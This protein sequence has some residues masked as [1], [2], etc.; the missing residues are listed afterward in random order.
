MRQL[1][2]GI[3]VLGIVL[4]PLVGAQA[5]DGAPSPAGEPPS[6]VAEVTEEQLQGETQPTN[7][8]EFLREFLRWL[9]RHESAPPRTK[10]DTALYDVW[11]AALRP[12]ASRMT[13]RV[14]KLLQR[15]YWLPKEG[16][17]THV[18]PEEW[19]RF[20]REIAGLMTELHG[21]WKQYVAARV[22][23]KQGVPVH[24][25]RPAGSYYGYAHPIDVW[26]R[27]HRHRLAVGARHVHHGKKLGKHTPG[28]N[29]GTGTLPHHAKGGGAHVGGKVKIGP[30][31]VGLGVHLGAGELHSYWH[32]L[33]R[34]RHGWA[35]RIRHCYGCELRRLARQKAVED[36]IAERQRMFDTVRDTLQQ[37]ML[38]LQVLTAAMQAQ[39]EHQ[40][41]AKF[42]AIPADDSRAT[43]ERQ[44][45]VGT[46]LFKLRE[47]RLD[48]ERYVGDSSAQ[49][50]HLL[51]GWVRAF[52]A[53]GA[54]LEE[55]AQPAGESSGE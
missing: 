37:Q 20:V 46:A 27:A 42:S 54:L 19:S 28:T 9:A 26:R 30:L 17:P 55:V 41:N 6:P 53:A 48:A 13:R 45:D 44:A 49:Y 18:K 11:R 33:R 50:G 16:E 2:R 29:P 22:K 47:A 40:L 8:V 3:C 32:L 52:K 12:R 15:K 1:V 5:E 10:W 43:A 35:W 23:V 36:F 14:L 4:V 39:A 34:Y 24:R 51:R 38:T 25:L 31:H 7:P 21:A